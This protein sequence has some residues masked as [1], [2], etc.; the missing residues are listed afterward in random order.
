MVNKSVSLALLPA[1]IFALPPGA[2]GADSINI[3]DLAIAGRIPAARSG[4]T[5]KSV[6][7]FYDFR[8][9]GDAALL[10]QAIAENSTD[11]TLPPGRPQGPEGRSL[12][13]P[14]SGL[15]FQT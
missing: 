5:V 9:A 4:A 1:M 10:K 7:A 12:P 11:R 6:R 3:H 2:L 13:H 8:N 14:N 15:P